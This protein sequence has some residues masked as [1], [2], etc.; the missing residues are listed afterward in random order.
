MSPAGVADLFDLVAVVS[1]AFDDAG[2]A[3]VSSWWVQVAAVDDFLV[4]RV[5][6]GGEQVRGKRPRDR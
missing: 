3:A 6:P 4:E 5:D 2:E 1:A